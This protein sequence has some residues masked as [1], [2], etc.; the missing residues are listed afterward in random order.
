MENA[1]FIIEIMDKIELIL[2]IVFLAVALFIWCMVSK[3]RYG[4]KGIIYPILF[5]AFIIF[6]FAGVLMVCE[7]NIVLGVG[8][9][10]PYTVLV[11]YFADKL[12]GDNKNN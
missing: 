8:L 4:K 1:N 7:N 6:A 2:G 10:V 3:D 5:L 12:F 9:L 11:V